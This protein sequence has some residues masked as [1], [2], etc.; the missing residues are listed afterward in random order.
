MNI[1]LKIKIKSLA[2]EARIIRDEELKLKRHR[3][4]GS[5]DLLGKYVSLHSHRTV[6]VRKSCRSTHLAYGF[7]RGRSYKRIEAT[8]YTKPDWAAIEKMILRYGVGDPRDLKQRFEEW[9]QAA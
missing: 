3:K 4:W 1:E 9:K 2:A 5:E 6:A 7:L 8:C